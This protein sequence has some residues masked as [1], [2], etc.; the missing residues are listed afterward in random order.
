VVAVAAAVTALTPVAA[1]PQA[2]F[3]GAAVPIPR[4]GV[5]LNGATGLIDTPV[6]ADLPD[7]E[8][9]FSISSFAGITRTAL[10]FQIFPRV[11]GT[12]RYAGSAGLNFGGFDDY[13]DRSFDVSLRLL[14]EG[15]YLPA[16]KVGLQD[17]IGTGI[18]S[19]E[20]VA[21][22]KT[23]TPRLQVTAGLGWGR[24]AGE[25]S[26]GSP[27]G[28]R[29]PVDIGQGGK[30]NIDQWFRGPVAPFGGVSFQATDRLTLLADYSSDGYILETGRA[31]QRS[32]ELFERQSSVNLGATYRFNDNVALGASWLYGSQ[33]GVQLTFS[34][35][36]Y[37][38]PAVGSLGPAPGP[39]QPRPSRAA[40]P[41]AYTT[42]WVAVP[43]AQATLL[44][45]LDADLKTQGIRVESLIA[46][47]DIVEV[48]I[49]NDIYDAEAQA[50]G[51]TA[52]ALTRTMPPSV[53]TFRIVPV[54]DG[55]PIST[56]TM[57]RS[58]V[59]A[60]VTAPDGAAA[61]LAVTGIAGTSPQSAGAATNPDLYPRFTYT[62]GPFVRTGYFDPDSPVRYAAGVRVGA[63]YRPAPGVVLAA[64][65]SKNVVGN[66]DE[67]RVNVA[68]LLPRVRTDATLYE[69]EGDPSL[70]QL[71][72]AYYFRTGT[73]TYAR[74]TAGYLE[75]MFGGVSG[76]VL[77]AP[78][79]SR[80]ALG[81]EVNYARQ[82]DFDLG[83]GF[84]DYDVVTGHVS[85]Y[86]DFGG[87]YRGRVDVGR[88]LAGDDG[89]TFAVDREFRNGWSVGAFA[90]LTDAS[91]EEFGEGSFDKGINVSIPVSWF[92][93]APTRA[94]L[95]T[96]IRPLTRDGGARLSVPGRLYGRVED[97]RRNSIEDQWG[98]VWR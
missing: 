87:G 61:L 26:V 33:V 66:L 47:G 2:M 70:D 49:R 65:V 39:V 97:Y 43:T 34:A 78:V 22:T 20:Y 50:I 88:Y 74:V 11:Q 29:P 59:E 81:V 73:N 71:T 62:I 77:Y 5:N 35:N 7:G 79:A 57:R 9:T 75:R 85:A 89:A 53:E 32:S 40:N 56:V 3:D 38:P 16:V 45:V 1:V 60:T 48:R 92:T 82:R 30:P 13:Y 76:E 90:T 51:R 36:P 63:Q 69:R 95:S 18:Y 44:E 72:A 41:G 64:S 98:R 84:R 52:R 54:V 31:R 37:R 94:G 27:F 23:L 19:G 96:T 14:D 4:P 93:N 55:L 46:T 86:Y 12:F 17:F 80:L 10:S 25:N 24:L 8:L 15:R 91:A 58:D 83:L 67:G 68:S 21:A 6:A 42:A 28:D